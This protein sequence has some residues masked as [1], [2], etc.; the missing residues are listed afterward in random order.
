M[1]LNNVKDVHTAAAGPVATTPGAPVDV[2]IAGA[3][4]TGL[5]LA[6]DLA[7][8]GVHA[9]VVER[10][11]HLSQGARGTGLQPRTQEVFDD[12]GV[13]GAVRAAGGRYPR[14]AL[15]ENGRIAREI[16]MVERVEPTPAIPYSN[17]LMVPQW[18]N[19]ELLYA[20]LTEL[21][22]GVLFGTELTGFEQDADGV[23]A[24]C[25]LPGGGIRTVRARYLVATDGGRSTV[26]KELGV[27]MSGPA[28][29]EGRRCSRMW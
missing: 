14:V 19:L 28:L 18:R 27:G 13:L 20:R 22:G 4:P 9:L 15:W 23:T 26:R 17:T 16:E 25:G 3:G 11:D 1:E 7:R 21:G 6:I 12:L 10:Q 5:A 8:R 2:L 24:R 29:P